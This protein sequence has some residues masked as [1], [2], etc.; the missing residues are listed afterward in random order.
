LFEHGSSEFGHFVE[1]GGADL[2]LRF[3]VLKTA[4]FQ[5]R[6]DDSFPAAD[7]GFN[8]AALIIAAVLATALRDFQ[9]VL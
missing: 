6:P 5:F 3:L 1:N 2:G 8:S 4:G 7:L 9:L